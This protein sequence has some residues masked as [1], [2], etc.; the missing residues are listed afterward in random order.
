MT[1][2]DPKR[3]AVLAQCEHEYLNG[4]PDGDDGNL[5]YPSLNT[6]ATRYNLPLRVVE[7][8]AA[9]RSWARHRET[10]RIRSLTQQRERRSF[11]IAR[12]EQIFN[13]KAM[14]L[15]ERELT[16]LG[17]IVHEHVQMASKAARQEKVNVELGDPDPMVRSEIPIAEIQGVV[18]SL[19][20]LAQVK[21]RLL[22]APPRSFLVPVEDDTD[23]VDEDEESTKAREVTL[24]EIYREQFKLEKAYAHEEIA[25]DDE[26]ETES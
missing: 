8:E 25:D 15:A 24:I 11:Q 12:L 3:A 13:D 14:A 20:G 4:I 17:R 5:L 21:E 2:R 6:L 9:K 26:D 16:V 1:V 10:R 22:G 19:E 23:E 18:R 7:L